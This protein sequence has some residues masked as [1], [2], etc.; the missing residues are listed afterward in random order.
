MSEVIVIS[1]LFNLIG[2]KQESHTEIRVFGFDWW[3]E[4]DGAQAIPSIEKQNYPQYGYTL[5]K[6]IRNTFVTIIT[7]IEF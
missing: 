2:G 6:Y 4:K 5:E 7:K 3:F 1:Y